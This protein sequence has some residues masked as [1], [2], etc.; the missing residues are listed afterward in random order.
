MSQPLIQIFTYGTLQPEE[1]PKPGATP[2]QKFCAE[3]M[4]R[5]HPAI[6]FGCLYHLPL[7]YPAMT[8]GADRV[9]GSLLSFTDPKILDVLDAYEKHEPEMLNRLF[10]FQ[11]PS[12]NDYQRQQIEVFSLSQDS[13]GFAW[14]YLMTLQQIQRLRGIPVESGRWD[15][16][17][18]PQ[19]D[20]LT[21]DYQ[22]RQVKF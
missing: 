10:S 16:K 11:K 20:S 13:F 3:K 6:A 14:A 8:I 9:Y 2:E 12:E 18:N 22:Q 21:A 1:I 4:I 15:A 19:P 7:G 17:N 5:A